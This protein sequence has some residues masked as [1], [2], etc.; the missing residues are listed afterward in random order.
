MEAK[1][2]SASAENI[3]P[4]LAPLVRSIESVKLDP[5]NARLHDDQN[6]EAI[7]VSLSKFGQR[8]PIVVRKAGMVIEAGNGTYRAAVELGW[9][10]IAMVVCDDPEEV[11][12]SYAIADNRS[13]ELASWDYAQLKLTWDEISQVDV[14]LALA[15]G[16]DEQAIKQFIEAADRDAQAAA[17]QAA[18]DAAPAGPKITLADRFIVPPFSVLD[19]RQG[20]WQSRKRTWLDMGIASE[21]GRASNLLKMSETVLEPDPA[22]RAEANKLA[23]F[24]DQDKL[25]EIMGGSAS[26]GTSIFD[27]V[28]C[29]LIYRWFS[30][31]GGS[32]LDPFAGGSVRG[33]VAS[34]LGRHY[35][36][37]ELREEQVASN[38][39]QGTDLCAAELM[40][41]WICGDSAVELDA[42]EPGFDLVFSCPPYADLETYSE[43]PADI[44][45]MEYPAFL[46]IYR[47]IIAKAIS[48]LAH[49]RFACFVVGEVREKD[50]RGFY[51]NFVPDSIRAFEDAGARFYNEMILV[52]S[53]GTL[54]IRVGRV[55]PASRKIGKTHQNVLVFCKGDPK[56]ASEAC[57]V[58]EI[59]AGEPEASADAADYGEVVE[60]LP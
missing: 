50:A 30:P 11:A 49:D 33:V 60:S 52:T 18:S 53:C 4:D 8:K 1:L 35:T 37:I 15:S 54:P 16:F 31:D 28:L 6:I 5:Q 39:Q 12:K 51:R 7:K 58:I 42:V 22:K 23:S 14:E 44:S 10:S 3:H 25:N 27:P 57:G 56:K 41:K 2:S 34:S 59:E 55:F 45:N 32:V 43:L 17:A 40:P 24:R 36:G 29:E 46:E 20:Y 13:A 19:A 9:R 21:E 38:V 47:A 48:K 26:T